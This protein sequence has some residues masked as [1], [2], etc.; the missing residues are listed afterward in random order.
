LSSFTEAVLRLIFFLPLVVLLAYVSLKYG[1]GKL[2]K[3]T[4][5][6][7]LQIVDRLSL[8]PKS[9]LFVIKVAEQYLLLAVT[10]QHIE[11]LKELPEYPTIN[12]SFSELEIGSTVSQFREV[13][14]SGFGKRGSK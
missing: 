5:N 14:K 9:G 1:L 13:I 7:Q 6:S 8:G 4:L 12:T 10:E 2:Q 11:I 3:N